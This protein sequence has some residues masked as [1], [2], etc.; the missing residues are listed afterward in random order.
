MSKKQLVGALLGALLLSSSMAT[1]AQPPNLSLVK[2]ELREYY[3]SGQYSSEIEDVNAQ[4]LAYLKK[5]VATRQ[6]N[7]KL[8][9]VL[10]IDETSLSNY[11]HMNLVDF[12]GTYAHEI[13]EE[14]KAIDA[15]IPSTLAL[16][17]YAKAHAV[18]VFFITGR[19]QKQRP[20]TEKNLHQVGFQDYDGLTFRPTHYREKS[21]IPYKSSVRHQITDK[22]YTIIMSVGD[23]ES[24]LAGGYADKTF[25]LPNPYYYLP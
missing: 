17:R 20:A 10:D 19:T 18:S 23:Q 15:V 24:D 12:G 9:I 13:A 14:D 5:R 22:G 8:A 2:H 11:Q 6:P 7:E 3:N 4:A 21:V 16:F 25:K 1:F